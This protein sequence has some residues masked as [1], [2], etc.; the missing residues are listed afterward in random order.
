MSQ[1]AGSTTNSDYTGFI[2]HYDNGRSIKERENFYSS[3]LKK[4]CATNWQEIDRTR[5]VALELVWH[6]QSKATVQKPPDPFTPD[7]WFFSHSGCMNMNSRKIIVVSRN[8]GY[9]KDGIV[10]ITSVMEDTGIIRIWT[11]A[12]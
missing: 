8:I 1:S 7:Q 3:K 4:K 11:R 2:A 6:G 10:H 5:L 12:V 9:V